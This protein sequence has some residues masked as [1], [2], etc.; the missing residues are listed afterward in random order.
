MRILA[1]LGAALLLAG[2]TTDARA[3]PLPDAGRP[4]ALAAPNTFPDT[5]RNP[6]REHVADPYLFFDNG[7]Y[8]LT[9]TAV[10]HVVVVRAPS[11]TGLATAPETTVWTP[12]QSG[13]GCCNLWAPEIHFLDGQWY[14]YYT[15]DDGTDSHHRMYALQASGP[16]GPYTFMGQLD[17]GNFHS[18]DGSVLQMPDGRLYFTWASGRSDGQHVF[19]APMSNPWTTSGPPVQ[20]INA[21]Q[22]WEQHNGKVAE[23]PVELVHDGQVYLAYSGSNCNS[24]DYAVG[25]MRYNGGD[26]LNPASWTKLPGPALH[27]N[28]PGWVWGTGHNG[29]FSSP[30]GSQTW[31]AYHG[32]TSSGGGV[33]GSCGGDRAL[34]I[35]RVTYATDGTPNLGSPSASWDTVTLPPGDPGAAVVPDG[36]YKLLPANNTGNALDVDACSTDNAANVQVWTDLDNDC[37]GWRLTYLDDGTYQFLNVHSGQSLDVGGCSPDNGANVDQWPY[38]GGDCQRW[39]LDALPDG[40]YRVTSKVGG[41]VLDVGGCSTQAGAN[42]DTWPYWQGDCQK[43][44]LVRTG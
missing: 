16:M 42:V 34:Y 17:T 30:D 6:V 3:M 12:P 40:F 1:A 38:W 24:P 25:L 31:I 15:A 23:A 9:Y 22:A 19:V 35:G 43:W 11:I 21:D 39:Y 33:Y 36:R 18:I 26:V 8:Y 10:F 41:R 20:L 13:A 28:D 37:Q 32:V 27:R 29:F 5:F 44:Q 4:S 7:Y 14:L 2:L